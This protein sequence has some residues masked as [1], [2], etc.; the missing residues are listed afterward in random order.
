MTKTKLIPFD[1]EKYKAGAKAVL[2]GYRD[3]V[4]I[5]NIFYTE[6]NET[7][8]FKAILKTGQSNYSWM[9]EYTIYGKSVNCKDEDANNANDLML[10]IPVEEKT[11]WIN[12][13]PENM[14]STLWKTEK[15]ADHYQPSHRLGKIKV[16]YTEEDLI[17]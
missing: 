5:L 14:S 1:Y 10:E 9:D 13:Y 7:Y 8:P 11:F 3:N 12:V 15:D 4:L 17:K 16:T 2:R 6:L